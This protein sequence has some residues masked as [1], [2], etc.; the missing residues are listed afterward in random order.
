ME[1]QRSHVD[2][3]EERTGV[4]EENTASGRGEVELG[5]GGGG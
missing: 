2:A 4:V 3:N 5:R 1:D